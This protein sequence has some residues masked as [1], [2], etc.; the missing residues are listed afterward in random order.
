MIKIVTTYLKAYWDWTLLGREEKELL[1]HKSRAFPEVIF[2]E[3]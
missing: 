1:K 3:L 2:E